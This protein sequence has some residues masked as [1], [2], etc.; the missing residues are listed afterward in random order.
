M[1]NPSSPLAAAAGDP[2]TSALRAFD[3]PRALA[4]GPLTFAPAIQVQAEGFPSLAQLAERAED[5]TAEHIA[6]L[7]SVPLSAKMAMRVLRRMRRGTLY[8]LLPSGEILRF[9]G[10]ESG[11]TGVLRINSYRAIA[12]VLAGGNVGI[13]EAYMDGDWDTPDL[14]AFLEVFAL[15]AQLLQEF[16][17][18]RFWTRQLTKLF[19]LMNRNSK[20]QARK[21]IEYHYDLGN[22]FYTQWLDRTMTYSSARFAEPGQDLAAAQENKYRSLAERIGLADGERVLEIGCGWGGFAEFAA[23]NFDCSVTGL[24]IS[25]EQL[26]FARKRMFEQGLADKVDIQ[27]RDYRDESGTYDRVASI[28]MFE[29]VGEE[30][31]PTFFSKVRDVLREGGRAGLQII[32]IAD[33]HFEGYRRNADFIQRYIFPGGMLP[34]PT[35][36]MKQFEAAG[37]SYVGESRFGLDYAHTLNEWMQRFESAWDKVRIQGFDERFRRMWRYYLA[38]CEAGFRAGNIDVTQIT[39]A[40]S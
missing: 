23:K 38:Y 13:A 25:K 6:G 26:E 11:R 33:D 2:T 32:T 29:A 37:L 3:D 35:A 4:G 15:N 5:A 16:F 14:T 1:V 17:K 9:D 24:T 19:H 7:K 18:G 21:N 28:E 34:S 8:V 27:Y 20:S 40:R 30:Y 10:D 39:L 36:L 22:A 12:K 31:W